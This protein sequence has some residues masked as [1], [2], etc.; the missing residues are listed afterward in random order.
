VTGGVFYNVK[1]TEGGVIF[2]L[3]RDAELQGAC[4]DK[5][6]QAYLQMF[7]R[8]PTQCVYLHCQ[9]GNNKSNVGHL[10]IQLEFML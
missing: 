10:D 5:R 6:G 1:Y 9:V 3:F 2:R 4:N 8:L 7:P